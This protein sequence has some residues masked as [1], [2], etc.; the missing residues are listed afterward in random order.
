[1]EKTGARECLFRCGDARFVVRGA[2]FEIKFDFGGVDFDRHVSR[3]GR[4]G[5]LG[6]RGSRG[7]RWR[8]RSGAVVSECVVEGRL[9]TEEFA[10]A[11]KEASM[12][13]L[14]IAVFTLCVYVVRDEM[15]TNEWMDD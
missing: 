15:K 14:L 13:L 10:E 5:H 6:R 2:S 9:M 8:R 4:A 11:S 1:L 3:D 12:G 7:G